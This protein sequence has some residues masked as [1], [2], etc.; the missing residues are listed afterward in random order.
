MAQLLGVSIVLLALVAA[1]PQSNRPLVQT[2]T[3]RSVD[4]FGS[5]FAAAQDKAAHAWAYLPIGQGGTF[6]NSGARG[7]G[8]TYWLRVSKSGDRGEIRLFGEEGA[9]SSESLIEAVDQ[10]R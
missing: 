8:A 5:C 1:V 9:R 6:T 4:A 7:S 3:S 10:C 2:A